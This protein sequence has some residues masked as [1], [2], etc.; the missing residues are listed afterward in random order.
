[1]MNIDENNLKNLIDAITLIRAKIKWKPNKDKPHLAKR[2]KLGHLSNNSSL[3]TYE[4]IIRQVIFNSEADVYIFLAPD[5]FYPSIT[6]I[7]K[8]RLWLVMFG[9]DGIM[10]TA[11]PPNNPEKY[12]ENEAFIYLGKLKDLI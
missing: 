10:E 6:T 12:L 1:M 4:E 3:E 5:S 9:L 2:I 7:I 11:F 8:G